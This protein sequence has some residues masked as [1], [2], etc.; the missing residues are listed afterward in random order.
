VALEGIEW[1]VA[2]ADN[3]KAKNQTA[4]DDESTAVVGSQ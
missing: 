2:T 4:V 3:K 1:Q